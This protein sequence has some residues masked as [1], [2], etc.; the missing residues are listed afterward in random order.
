MRHALRVASFASLLA[1]QAVQNPASS[2]A[3]KSKNQAAIQGKVVNLVTTEPVRKANLSLR[4]ALGG[5][6]LTAAA[7]NEGKFAIEGINPGRF[8]LTADR[9]GFV[10]ENYGARRPGAPGTVIELKAGQ[11]LADLVFKLT[12]QGVIAGHITDDEG[13]PMSGVMVQALQYQ[14]VSGKKHLVPAGNPLV[15]TNDLGEFRIPNLSPGRYYIATSSQRLMD[16]AQTATGDQ[17]SAKNKEGFVPTYY[18][19]ASEPSAATAVDLAPGAEAAGINLRLL[20]SRVYRV[21]GKVMNAVTG[22]PL[23]PA[24]LM[25][26]R[27][28]AGGM[29]TIPS[30]MQAVQNDKGTFELKNV[31]P[32]SYILMAMSP[33][34]QDLMITSTTLEIDDKDVEDMQVT[35]GG[36]VEIAVTARLEGQPVPDP[37]Q[38]KN[39]VDLSAVRVT[40]RMD[41]N[42]MASLATAQIG[43]ES[44]TVL[45]HVNPDKY[46][47]AVSGLPAGTYLKSA[48]FGDQDAFENGIDVRSGS[49]STL[50]LSFAAPAGEVS[51]V[52]RNE[53]GDPASGALV[54]LIAKDPKHRIDLARTAAA[55]QNGA[56]RI[57]GIVP[58][59]YI[60]YAWEDIE[61][62]AADDPDFVKPFESRG[63]KVKVSEASKEPVSLTAISAD[64]LAAEK[65]KH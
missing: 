26:Y 21:T 6:S 44:K 38:P 30:S 46:E 15:Q 5:P 1:A 32:G 13:E 20:K 48:K 10:K 65:A 29:S 31:P 8:V 17:P 61:P 39:A 14:Y 43:K 58:G 23:N 19:N 53:K 57:T 16:L 11:T 49:A 25:A 12:P 59:E 4:P 18:P 40:L 55:D 28:E 2:D 42:P 64:S 60:A 47:L 54:T 51:G 41:N 27:R 63:V 62:G 36:G 37:S 3:E 22:A 52:V 34:P 45:K 56:V 50:D 33:N 9:Q 24:V 35:V 7:D